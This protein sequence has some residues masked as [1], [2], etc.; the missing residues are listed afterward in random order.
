MVPRHKDVRTR[1]NCLR[2][3]PLHSLSFLEAKAGGQ[4]GLGFLVPGEEPFPLETDRTL[5]GT[6]SPIFR[7]V[8]PTPMTFP[9][10]VSEGQSFLVSGARGLLAVVSQ[11]RLLHFQEFCEPLF[12]SVQFNTFC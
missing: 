7:P 4:P 5:P 1:T 2:E 6:P 10:S 3:G 9:L 8:L 11:D 12:I